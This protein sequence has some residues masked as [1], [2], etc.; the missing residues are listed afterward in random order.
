VSHAEQGPDH[1]GLGL[2]RAELR[3]RTRAAHSTPGRA[4]QQGPRARHARAAPRSRCHGRATPGAAPRASHTPWSCQAACRAIHAGPRRPAPRQGELGQGRSRSPGGRTAPG[5]GPPRQD[6]ARV[7]WPR[8]GARPRAAGT[9]GRAL[10]MVDGCRAAPSR[11]GKGRE[12]G[13]GASSPRGGGRRWLEQAQRRRF[14]PRLGDGR[15]E[16]GRRVSELRGEEETR[17]VGERSE[18]GAISLRPTCGPH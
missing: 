13:G 2:R 1:V 15:R 8:R 12:R 14:F 10:V 18:Q 3:A 7:P 9:P 16:R 6:G 4:R 5:Q 11:G 17:V